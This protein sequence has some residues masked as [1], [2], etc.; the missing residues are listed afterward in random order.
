[1]AL[2]YNL[3]YTKKNK[4]PGL[5]TKLD[6]GAQSGKDIFN[7]MLDKSVNHAGWQKRQAESTSSV[8][9][10]K[11]KG[12]QDAPK[13]SKDPMDVA[14]AVDPKAVKSAADSFKKGSTAT[15]GEKASSAVGATAGVAAAGMEMGANAIEEKAGIDYD[16]I[17]K[18]INEGGMAGAGALSGAGK[19]LAMGAAIGSVFPGPG[20]AI[21]AAAGAVIGGAVGFFKGR[22]EGKE[23]QIERTKLL[24][25]RSG[26][27]REQ[28]KGL[29]ADKS[30]K[31]M[32]SVGNSYAGMKFGGKFYMSKVSFKLTEDIGPITKRKFVSLP[33]FK[34]GGKITNDNNIVPNGVS[35]EEKNDLGTKGMPVIKCGKASCEKMYEIESD[36]LILTLATTS[37]IEKLVKGGNTKKLG[38]F[39]M[40]ELLNN[41]HAYSDNYK[42]LN[43]S[44]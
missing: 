40:D 10:I 28:K 26:A 36:E 30:N 39:V 38:K 43:E 31:L 15:G 44:I 37:E 12:A 22:K 35:H 1:M 33:K 20:T 27:Q 32:S 13:K 4:S 34:R 25:R 2:E 9:A 5:S 41:T 16:D 17:D 11:P 14:S 19:G 24:K 3:L 23:A 42:F 18:E 6:I 8:S 29:V 7:N 21:G